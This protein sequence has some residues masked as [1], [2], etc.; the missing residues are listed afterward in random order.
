MERD[1]RDTA[2]ENKEACVLLDKCYEIREV[3]TGFSDSV[4]A[5]LQSGTTICCV[6]SHSFDWK[7]QIY[8]DY[9]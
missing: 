7:Y 8:G 1:L 6:Y 5:V 9:M 3:W 4:T 2:G